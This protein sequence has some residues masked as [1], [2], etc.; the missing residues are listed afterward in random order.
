VKVP[1]K[2]P[3]PSTS[4]TLSAD[5]ALTLS[6]DGFPFSAGARVMPGP[7]LFE[8]RASGLEPLHL[9]LEVK[10]FTPVVLEL[11]AEGTRLVAVVAG[12]TAPGCEGLELEPGMVAGASPSAETTAAA[13][14]TGDCRAAFE[15]LRRWPETRRPPRLLEAALSLTGRR[16]RRAAASVAER[17]AE[18]ARPTEAALERAW[19]VARWDAT[20]EQLSHATSQL[21]SS[22]MGVVTAANERMETLSDAFGTATAREETQTQ[23]DLVEAATRVMRTLADGAVA[24]HPTD[25]AWRA[26][27]QAAL[28]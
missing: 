23:R 18:R 19:L 3:A 1:A 13:L 25:C 15:Q 12:A 14:S 26:T 6:V 27:V 10:A 21:A 24:L 22:A 4:L 2:G 16:P 7:H 5:P 9:P 17:L 11:R 28:L 20:T 8:A